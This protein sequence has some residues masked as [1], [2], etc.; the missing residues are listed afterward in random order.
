MADTQFDIERWENEGGRI[1][2]LDQKSH[3]AEVKRPEDKRLLKAPPGKR[4][5]SS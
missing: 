1:G 5:E 4:N 2:D 3:N